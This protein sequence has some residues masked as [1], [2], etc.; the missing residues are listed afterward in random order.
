MKSDE[1]NIKGP[2]EGPFLF[3]VNPNSG[4][5]K[6]KTFFTAIKEH[7]SL[8]KFQVIE[9]ESRDHSVELAQNAA[10]N[11]YKAVIAVGGDGSV[12]EIGTQLIDTDVALGIIPTGS[13]NGISRHLGISNSIPK[14]ID[15]ILKGNTRTFDTLL[16]NNN[17]AIGF[18]GIGIDAHV[19]KMFENATERG[20]SNYV[21][22]S[23]D[24]FT[25]Y[26]PSLFKIK[27]EDFEEEVMAYTIVCANINQFG[28][29][30]FINPNAIDD[31]GELELVLIKQMAPA[32]LMPVASRLFLKSLHKSKWVSVYKG[33][34]FEIENI[35]EAPLQIDGEAIGITQSITFE[36]QPHSLTVITP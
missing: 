3:I 2:I 10:S 1:E 15:Q 16:I 5:G 8:K 19:A 32:M 35:G 12:H 23:I 27:G 34:R 28:N 36:V 4:T 6:V 22:L 13:G 31:D 11:G 30:A 20:F 24:A 17:P 14:A 29:N 7:K 25:N 21:K 26:K 33:K 9:S 18:A